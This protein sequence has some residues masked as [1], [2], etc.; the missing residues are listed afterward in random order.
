MFGFDCLSD[1]SLYTVYSSSSGCFEN[2]AYFYCGTTKD[3]L[4]L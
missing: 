3:F 1:M 4:Y 2:N